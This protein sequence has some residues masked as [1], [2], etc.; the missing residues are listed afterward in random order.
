MSPTSYQTAPPRGSP[1][2]CLF[3][4]GAVNRWSKRSPSA[5]ALG[6]GAVFFGLMAALSHVSYRAEEAEDG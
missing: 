4:G 2:L 5:A 3:F 6:E 1:L